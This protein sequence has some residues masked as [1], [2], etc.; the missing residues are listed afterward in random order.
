MR[1]WRRV[2]FWYIFSTSALLACAMLG[3]LYVTLRVRT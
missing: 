2:T 3:L 1:H